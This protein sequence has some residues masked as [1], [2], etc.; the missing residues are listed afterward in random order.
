M[1]VFL[2]TNE[3]K[4]GVKAPEPEFTLITDS[5]LHLIGSVLL[6]SG[7]GQELWHCHHSR[8][9]QSVLLLLKCEHWLC[10]LCSSGNACGCPGTCYQTISISTCLPQILKVA[11]LWSW[12]N[13]V[14]R[15][16]RT[17]PCIASVQTVFDWSKSYSRYCTCSCS[18]FR[19]NNN[20]TKGSPTL[21]LELYLLENSSPNWTA[22]AN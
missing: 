22:L 10:L 3:A 12:R 20:F 5:V 2:Q 15:K 9:Y 8:S 7:C 1:E 4:V 17:F 21:I 11:I 18:V 14:K 19:N 16:S 6:S 13:Q